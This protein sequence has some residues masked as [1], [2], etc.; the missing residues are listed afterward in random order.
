MSKFSVF[1]QF[2]K[3]YGWTYLLGMVLLFAIDALFLYVPSLTGQAVNTLYSNKEGLSLYIEIFLALAIITFVFK[4]FSRRLL[5]GSIRRFEYLLRRTLFHHALAIPATYYEQHG[6]GKVMALMTNDITSLRVSLGLGLMIL[7]DAIF[8]GVCAFIILVEHLSLDVAIIMLLPVVLIVAA[9]LCVTKNMRHRQREAQNVYSDMTEFAQELFK[10]MSLLRMYNKEL[11]SR[12]RFQVENKRNYTCNMKVALL[13]SLL[14][15]LTYIAPFSC[16]AITMYVCG[17][18]II[19]GTMNVG[20]FISITGYVMLIIG[21]LMSIGSLASVLQKGLASLDRVHA[22]LQIPE[23]EAGT[24][25]DKE[26]VKTGNV[27]NFT[28][29]AIDRL[30]LADIRIQHLTYTYPKAQQPS[31]VDVTYTISKGAFIGLVGAPGSGKTTLFKLL[32]Q[33]RKPPANSIFIGDTDIT[34]ISLAVLR[35]SIAYISSDVLVMSTTMEE[36][37][38]M[39]EKTRNPLRLD[40]SVKRSAITEDLQYRFTNKKKKSIQ[41][42]GQNLSGGQRQRV[43]IARGFY[44]E[45]P[46]LLLDDSISALDVGTASQVVDSLREG[47]QQ[48]ILFISQRLEALRKADCILVFKEGRLVEFGKE[49][50]LVKANGEYARI[51]AKQAKEG[52]GGVTIG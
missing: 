7:V 32:L 5:L 19:A 50:E 28:N 41:E 35:H 20:D 27:T 25:Y 33:L 51:Y 47:G 13:D 22:F 38:T 49:A 14:A 23:E 31:L 2:F 16:L 30:P 26:I 44:K 40:E 43:H 45:A 36:N 46:Y 34:K 18:R 3:G 10:G 29:E 17:S 1:T 15:P 52:R 9:M 12:K 6:P 11:L 48:T 39:E 37:I 8:F 42:G 4:F 24:S 21:P